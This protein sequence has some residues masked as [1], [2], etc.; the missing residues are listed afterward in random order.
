MRASSY[1]TALI[2]SLLFSIQSVSAEVSAADLP[3]FGDSA[4]S[5]ISPEMERRIGEAVMRQARKT[6]TIVDDP[7]VQSYIRSLGY[8]LLSNSDDEGLYLLRHP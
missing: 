4:G 6:A 5:V 8:Q 7:E 3:E 2:L 1:L